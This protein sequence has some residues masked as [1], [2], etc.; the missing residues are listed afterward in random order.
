MFRL[1]RE[2]ARPYS[3]AIDRD[4]NQLLVPDITL[5]GWWTSLPEALVDEDLAQGVAHGF[6]LHIQNAVF[7]HDGD[8]GFHGNSSLTDQDWG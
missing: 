2:R 7:Q 5:E 4:G 8:T 1:P 6:A 3:L